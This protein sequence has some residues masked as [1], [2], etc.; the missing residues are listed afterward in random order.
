MASNSSKPVG[1]RIFYA[2]ARQIVLQKRK[3][4]LLAI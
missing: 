2:E 3:E 4:T 1:Q